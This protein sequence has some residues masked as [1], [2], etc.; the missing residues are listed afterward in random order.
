MQASPAQFHN[1]A[2]LGE[3][4]TAIAVY[5]EENRRRGAV[6]A[7]HAGSIGSFTPFLEIGANAGHTRYMVANRFEADGFALDISADA[8]RHGIAE[9]RGRGVLV[10]CGPSAVEQRLRLLVGE[11]AIGADD[12]SPEPSLDDA[13]IATHYEQRREDELVLVG[14]ERAEVVGEL[15]RQH[16]DRAIHEIDRRRA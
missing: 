4:D 5:E 7:A 10:R 15:R 3:P 2:S 16:R 11:T 14:I 12:A 9:C 1:F 8:L 6:L 13:R